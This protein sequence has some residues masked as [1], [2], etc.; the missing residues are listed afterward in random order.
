MNRLIFQVA[1]MTKT[2]QGLANRADIA[3]S[4][5]SFDDSARSTP[6]KHHKNDAHLSKILGKAR[7][8]STTGARRRVPPPPPADE[9]TDVTEA[10]LQEEEEEEETSEDSE[11]ETPASSAQEVKQPPQAPPRAS[12][13]EAASSDVTS[14]LVTTPRASTASE[15]T[16]SPDAIWDESPNS[17]PFKTFEDRLAFARALEQGGAPPKNKS[18]KPRPPLTSQSEP[19]APKARGRPSDIEEG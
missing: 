6:T 13:A 7:T 5:L 10:T 14:S 17:P 2:P 12:L 4:P 16:L 8:A 19:P 3:L 9:E 11:S 1:E 15:S 18:K